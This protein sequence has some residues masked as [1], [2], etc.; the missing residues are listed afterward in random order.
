VTRHDPTPLLIFPCNG[1][2]LEALDCLGESWRCVGFVDDNAQKQES[3]AYGHRVSSRAT[4]VDTPGAKVL[5]VPG[6][7]NTYRSRRH[8]VEGL[9]L[10][11]LRFAQ[12]IHPAARISARAVIGYNVL[13]MAGVVITSNAVIGDH[14]CILPN[15]VI[16]HDSVIGNWTLVGSN[17]T[18]AGGCTVGQCCY[19][20]SGSSLING[21]RIEDGAMVGIGSN[22]IR[23]VATHTCVAGN[24]A[25]PLRTASQ[26]AH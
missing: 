3:G 20:G 17:V 23:N 9:Q 18:V 25:K 22:V 12:V 15:T 2:G 21:V 6:S 5:A 14:V 24:P 16:H 8:V 13:I 11:P 10:A 1:N 19:I 26:P 4:F 7:P